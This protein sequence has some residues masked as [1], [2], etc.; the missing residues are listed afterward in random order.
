[1]ADITIKGPEAHS[2]CS[3]ENIYMFVE[4]RKNVVLHGALS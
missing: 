2:P 4:M 1:M 3:L